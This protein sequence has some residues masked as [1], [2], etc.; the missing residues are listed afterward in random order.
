MI[1]VCMMMKLALMLD[2]ISRG[3]G[4]YLRQCGS[5]GFHHQPRYGGGDENQCDNFWDWV[6]FH[7][8][9]VE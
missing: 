8:L 1:N 6:L 3:H 5:I 7:N 4:T 2:I 9:N